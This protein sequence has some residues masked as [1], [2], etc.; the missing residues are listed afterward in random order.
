MDR[1]TFL[2]GLGGVVVGL[3]FL[4]S[5]AGKKARAAA[6]DRRLIVFFECNGVNMAGM[7]PSTPWGALTDASFTGKSIAP[8][9]PYRNKLLIPRGIHMEPIGFGQSTIPTNGCDHRM[10]MG[11]K[12]TAMPL[13]NTTDNYASGPSVDQVVAQAVNPPGRPPMT[14]LVG[15]QGGGVLG[16]ISYTGPGQPVVGDNNPF[17]V[18][19]DMMNISG[20]T[21]PMNDPDALRRRSVLDLVKEQM[22]DLKAAGLSTADQQKL[23]MHYTAIRDV[24]MGMTSTGLVACGLPQSVQDELGA[25]NANT[26]AND[27]QYKTVGNLQMQ[28]LAIGM[29]CGHSRVG[30]LQWGRGSGGPIFTWDGINHQ[31]NHHKLSHGN[32]ADDNSGSDVTGYEQML[33]DIDAWYMG[34]FKYLLD[35]LDAYQE[36]DG[37]VLD[38]SAV[39]YMN[40]LSEGKA[41]DFRDLPYII[42]GSC[43]GYLKQGQYVKLT[44]RPDSEM[45]G[46]WWDNSLDAPHNRLLITLMNAMGMTASGG[47][48]VT[49]FGHSSLPTGEFSQLKA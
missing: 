18:Y 23:D 19:R 12:L 36:A 49:S 39:V 5:L 48:P 43:G 44:N 40:E 33:F 30:S 38:N 31:Y 26:I 1:R 10:G 32:T 20:N 34:R 16:S 45:A 42:A 4:E 28:V 2:R 14:L 17:L 11:H 29:A 22:D 8:L 7:Y 46:G 6:A 9:L 47:A 35:L 27:A 41:H 3:P 21:M 37:T 24:E 13:Q 15:P 25:L